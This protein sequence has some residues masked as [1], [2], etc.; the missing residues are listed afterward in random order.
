MGKDNIVVKWSDNHLSTYSYEW[1]SNRSFSKDS[2]KFYMENVYQPSRVL[3]DKGDFK[4]IFHFYDY[5][6]I[7]TKCV[8]LK[9]NIILLTNFILRKEKFHQWLRDLATYGVVLIQNAPTSDRNIVRN[10]ANK[11]AFIRKSHYGYLLSNYRQ[12]NT[13]VRECS[14]FREDYEITAKPNARN[15]AYVPRV[16]QL[17]TD[18]PYYDFVPGVCKF[19]K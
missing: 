19:S 7:I 1:L 3:W 13:N 6:E 12:V 15:A 8:L 5:Q 16:L 17:H 10:L 11:I 9:H 14:L 2:Q 18:L 4:E